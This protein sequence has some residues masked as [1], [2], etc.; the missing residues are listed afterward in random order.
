M[1]KKVK[2]LLAGG[3]LVVGM[4]GNVF[5][6]EQNRYYGNDGNGA[7]CR[8]EHVGEANKIE[9]P[10]DGVYELGGVVKVTVNGKYAKVEPIKDEHEYDLAEIEA[11]H[12][13]GGNGYHCYV[14]D[15]GN[16]ETWA[17]N[18]SCPLNKGENI[19]NISHITVIYK[20][21]PKSERPDPD[22][23]GDT[24]VDPKPEEVDPKPEEPTKPGAGESEK[25]MGD[26]G[27]MPMATVAVASAAA[28]VVLN[29]KDEE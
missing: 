12:L 26:V 16:G 13:K 11:I 28:L 9:N 21:V 3:L 5:A 29:K 2:S 4:S 27:I 1:N 18:L 8:H 23:K 17:E 24:P 25:P 22:G 6:L 15:K 7:P 19:P 10:T 14:L 20:E